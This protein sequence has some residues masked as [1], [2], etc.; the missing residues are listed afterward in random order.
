MTGQLSIYS[1]NAR[2]DM[3]ISESLMSKEDQ[4]NIV[5]AWYD[6]ADGFYYILTDNQRWFMTFIWEIVGKFTTSASSLN[7][8]HQNDTVAWPI[9]LLE[10]VKIEEMTTAIHKMIK[11]R[12]NDGHFLCTQVDFQQMPTGISAISVIFKTAHRAIILP[13]SCI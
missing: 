1:T 11:S 8:E 4:N 7:A 10:F 3:S 9:S 12:E 13:I 6:I 5:G 2:W